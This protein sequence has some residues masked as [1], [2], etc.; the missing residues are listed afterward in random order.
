MGVTLL[1]VASGTDP[2]Y[3]ETPE[4]ASNYEKELHEKGETLLDQV[5][6][7]LLRGGIDESRIRLKAIQAGKKTKISDKILEHLKERSYDTIVVGKHRLTM[8]QEFL[9]GSV[10][11]SLVRQAPINVLTVKGQG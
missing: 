11:V 8:S 4:K 1:W 7:I 3:F 5:K 2:D 10:A 9:F 6:E